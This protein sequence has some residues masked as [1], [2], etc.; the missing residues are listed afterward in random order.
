MTAVDALRSVHTLEPTAFRTCPSLTLRFD[1]GLNAD[2]V[3]PLEVLKHAHPIL[4]A[5][6]DVQAL[7][8][9]TW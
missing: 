8:A 9:R 5:V 7:E 2:V 1:K 3:D 4:R 6:P